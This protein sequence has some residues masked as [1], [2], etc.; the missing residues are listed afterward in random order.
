M[1]QEPDDVENLSYVTPGA[2]LYVLIIQAQHQLPLIAFIVCLLSFFIYFA[3]VIVL[4]KDV[5]GL[6]CCAQCAS[7]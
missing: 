5:L 2:Q 3:T 6:D 7:W 4:F 1:N